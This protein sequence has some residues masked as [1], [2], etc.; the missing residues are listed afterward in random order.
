MMSAALGFAGFAVYVSQRDR[1]FGR[2]ILLS[3]SLA[4]AATFDTITT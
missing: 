1:H 4:A 2:T 3:H